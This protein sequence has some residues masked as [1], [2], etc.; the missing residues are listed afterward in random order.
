M[1]FVTRILLLQESYRSVLENLIGFS[2]VSLC[3]SLNVHYHCYFHHQHYHLGH[4]SGFYWSKNLC[5]IWN[6]LDFLKPKY[7]VM[8]VPA[9]WGFH[10]WTLRM[11]I[12]QI[13]PKMHYVKKKLYLLDNLLISK[14]PIYRDLFFPS[15]ASAVF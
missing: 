12:F 6:K 1:K 14:Y 15:S 13:A 11:N 3:Y 8:R 2:L 9:V 7:S 10:E 4:Y 5:L